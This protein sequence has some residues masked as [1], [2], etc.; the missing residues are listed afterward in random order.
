[1]FSHCS[2]TFTWI[3]LCCVSAAQAT[4]PLHL[5]PGALVGHLD[6]VALVENVMW[7]KHPY[8]NLRAIP[9][10]LKIVAPE[11]DS[12]LVQLQKEAFKNITDSS[13]EDP[14]ALLKMYT[15]R[16]VFVNDTVALAL[17]SYYF[18]LRRSCP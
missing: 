1:M 8:A 3:L 6:R 5:K 16:I 14:L 9:R 4:E 13:L 12:A 18:R 2:G 11:I 7:V 15:L 10:R 17:E